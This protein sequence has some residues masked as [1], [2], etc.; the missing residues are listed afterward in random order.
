M[1]CPHQAPR[2]STGNKRWWN[3]NF[4]IY[5]LLSTNL[6]FPPQFVHLVN[7]HPSRNHAENKVTGD[8]RNVSVR[9][10]DVCQGGYG[11]PT[12]APG[13]WWRLHKSLTTTWVHYAARYWHWKSPLAR[14]DPLGDTREYYDV[15]KDEALRIY[16]RLSLSKFPQG[17][18][19][20]SIPTNLLWNYGP[21]LPRTYHEKTGNGNYGESN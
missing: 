8:E 2:I 20:Y 19:C 7:I 10:Q 14:K 15:G 11:Q 17:W 3:Q 13:S 21:S 1:G 4:Y 18:H 5:W 16:F 9:L 12:S 6:L